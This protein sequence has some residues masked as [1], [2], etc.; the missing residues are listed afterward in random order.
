MVVRLGDCALVLCSS[1]RH[2]SDSQLGPLGATLQTKEVF[3]CD[4][5]GVH[6]EDRTPR[7]PRF[8]LGPCAAAPDLEA[9]I[10]RCDVEF[11]S[12]GFFCNTSQGYTSAPPTST[13]NAPYEHDCQSCAYTHLYS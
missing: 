13:P 8:S 9:P 3:V 11:I 1:E 7:A 2:R 5:G 4:S 6:L 10:S 12:T